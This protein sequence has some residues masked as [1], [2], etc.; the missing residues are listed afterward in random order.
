MNFQKVD[1]KEGSYEFIV[2]GMK[3]PPNFRKSELF[4]DIY[5]QTADYYNIQQ[6]ANYE[7]LWIQTN[8]VATIKDFTRSQSVELFGVDAIYTIQFTPENPIGKDGIITLQW[9]EQVKWN[10]E[11]DIVCKVE[12]YQSFN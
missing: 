6:V 9:T 4:T 10:Q 5:F 1:Y 3:N 2:H 11:N 7:N 12:T 8:E